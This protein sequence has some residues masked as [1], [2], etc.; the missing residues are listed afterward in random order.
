MLKIPDNS[1]NLL[2]QCDIVLVISVRISLSLTSSLS[3]L[4]HAILLAQ[5]QLQE[6]RT[7]EQAFSF[8]CVYVWKVNMHHEIIASVEG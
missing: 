1:R 6:Y 7:L 2:Q 4:C 3:P 5:D 8:N